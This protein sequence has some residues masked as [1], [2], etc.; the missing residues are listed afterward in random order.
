MELRA[1]IDRGDVWYDLPGKTGRPETRPT[2]TLF[3]QVPGG[4]VAVVRWPTTIGGW[5]KEFTGSGRIALRFKDSDIG[6]RVW[7]D[8]VATPT[9]DAPA[10]TPPRTLVRPIGGGKFVADTDLTGPGYASAFGLVMLIHHQ[11]REHK[12]GPPTFLDN[13]IRTHGTVSYQSILRGESHGCHRL[14][15]QSAI[16]LTGFLLKHRNH[17]TKGLID[18][19]YM[20][21]VWWQGRKYPLAVPHRGY[22]TELTPPVPVEVLAGNIKGRF[23]RPPGQLVGIKEKKR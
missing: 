16:Q 13:G 23:A 6:P 8:L 19:P 5:K 18:R 20:K 14:F 9:W 17:V 4:E 15:T 3:A 1:E 12:G 2:M 10:T 21:T 7:R 11:M 22:L